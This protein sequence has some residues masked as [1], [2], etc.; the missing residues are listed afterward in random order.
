MNNAIPVDY[1]TSD[2]SLLLAHQSSLRPDQSPPNT[3]ET[4]ASAKANLNGE[5]QSTSPLH[6]DQYVSPMTLLIENSEENDSDMT[7]PISKP[8]PQSTG[9]HSPGQLKNPN[10][11]SP[12]QIQ[13]NENRK[14]PKSARYISYF[15]ISRVPRRSRKKW[16][17]GSI[18]DKTPQDLFAEISAFAGRSDLQEILF[19]L[20]TS[21]E[22]EYPVMPEDVKGFE[23]LKKHF[24]QAIARDN[25]AG[26]TDFE[27]ELILNPGETQVHTMREEECNDDMVLL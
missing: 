2:D 11:S 19:K 23:M 26:V 20:N 6:T 3:I 16:S 25:K 7:K 13:P 9:S 21:E 24:S 14:G 5:I 10:S 8:T 1:A 27:I 12:K 15:V 22:M 4:E 17:R 18:K